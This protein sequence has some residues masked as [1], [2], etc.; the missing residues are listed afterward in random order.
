MK[1]E[2]TPH[3]SQDYDRKHGQDHVAKNPRTMKGKHPGEPDA[4]PT[5]SD[6]TAE[7]IAKGHPTPTPAMDKSAYHEDKRESAREEHTNHFTNRES[8]KKG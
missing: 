8:H 7:L 5:I 4:A 2:P 3:T 6:E 1:K